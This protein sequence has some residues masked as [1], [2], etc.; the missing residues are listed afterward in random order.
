MQR[1]VARDEIPKAVSRSAVPHGRDT[2][3]SCARPTWR[4]RRWSRCRR[5]SAHAARVKS[6]WGFNAN[7]STATT[8]SPVSAWDTASLGDSRVAFIC[9]VI[10]SNG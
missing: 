6:V 8:R 5:G 10:T 1:R 9:R 7:L 4:W 3:S 2:A